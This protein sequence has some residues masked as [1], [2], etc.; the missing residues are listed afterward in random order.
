MVLAG[1]GGVPLPRRVVRRLAC[2][3]LAGSAPYSAIHRC[4]SG[5]ASDTSADEARNSSTILR[6]VCT[7][8]ES[9]CTFMPGSALRE[10]AGTRVRDPSTS[11]TQTRQ[12]LTGVRFSR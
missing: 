3:Y 4:T 12:T 7:R 9:V 5:E 2:P 11:T 6:D 10:H 8:S 1:P